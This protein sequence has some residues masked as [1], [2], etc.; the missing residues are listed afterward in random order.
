[1]YGADGLSLMLDQSLFSIRMRNTV[2]MGQGPGPAGRHSSVIMSMSFRAG[3]SLDLAATRIVHAPIFLPFFL[4]R[5]LMSM[6][7]PQGDCAVVILSFLGS[8]WPV[9]PMVFLNGAGTQP[10]WL[11]HNWSLKVQILPLATWHSVLPSDTLPAWSWTSTR[12]S[13]PAV[14]CA[15]R[16]TSGTANAVAAMSTAP[17]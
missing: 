15:A 12:H 13:S 6:N 5:T 7:A 2:R 16:P 11:R 17:N 14:S 4:V 10:G 8:Q 3:L 1:M 9:V